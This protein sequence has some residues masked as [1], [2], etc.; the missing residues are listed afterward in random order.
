MKKGPIIGI[1][2]AVAAMSASALQ[3]GDPM[4]DADTKMQGADGT[5]QSLSQLKGEKGT[6]VIFTC[7][8]CPFVDAWQAVMVDLGN[9]YSKKGIGVVFV[10]SNDPS[11]KGDTL[12]NMKAKAEKEG[13]QFAYLQ[14]STSDVARNF[15]A[16]KTP[17][18]FL[19]DAAGK[20]VYQGAVGEGGRSVGDEIWLKDALEALVAGQKIEN[21]QTKAVG[22]GIKFR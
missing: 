17:D 13:Y 14:D 15:G 18:V 3:I 22:C 19:F 7:N 5:T 16:K 6:L 9:T 12:E 11:V 2:A 4:V 21:A 20:L 8:K 10:N 1:L